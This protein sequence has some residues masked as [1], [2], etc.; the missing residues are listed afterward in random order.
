MV[1]KVLTWGGIAFLIFFVA[2]RPN[3][4]ADVVQVARRRDHGH[5]PGVRRLLHQPRR[6]AADGQP[7]RSTLRPGRPRPGTP[8]ARHRADPADRA[9]RRPGLRCR[10]RPVRRSVP[11][12]TTSATATGP[13]MPARVVPV[14]PGSVIRRPATSRRRSPRTS[15]PGCGPTR[16]ACRSARGGCC[17]W[18]TSPARWSP[19]TSSPPSATGASGSGTGSTSPTRC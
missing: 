13:A 9:R 6:L 1:K 5:R 4:A 7:L 8:R 19:A 3:S 2:Y 17:R 10:S 16:P 14:G 15:W 12:R 11:I 18:R